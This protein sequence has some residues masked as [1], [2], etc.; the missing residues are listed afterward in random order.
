MKVKELQ[1]RPLPQ[2]RSGRDAAGS[3]YLDENSLSASRLM[4]KSAFWPLRRF[5][6]IWEDW[7]GAH[8]GGTTS[9]TIL[10]RVRR[11][12]T[13]LEIERLSDSYYA[14]R[15]KTEEEKYEGALSLHSFTVPYYWGSS[16]SIRLRDYLSLFHSCASLL[17]F[18]WTFPFILVGSRFASRL[19]SFR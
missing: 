12:S 6:L 16:R 18:H 11:R 3:S 5:N 13:V 1:H 15:N 2:A 17:I 10:N 4:W 14:A 8:T 7:R 9:P 19:S